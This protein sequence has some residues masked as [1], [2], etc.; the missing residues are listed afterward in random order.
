MSPAINSLISFACDMALTLMSRRPLL[1]G[2]FDAVT[3][4]RGDEGHGAPM[5]IG[6]LGVQPLALG[7]PAPERGHVGLGPRPV[8]E[9]EMPG[10]KSPLILAPLRAPPCD[11][12]AQLFG[13]KNAFF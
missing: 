1:D 3:A 5:A 11:P 4:Q 2:G 9:D 7:S 6:H 13:G 10:I 8:D 12:G